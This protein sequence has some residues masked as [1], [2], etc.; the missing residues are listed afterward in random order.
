[1]VD[2]LNV[3][4][5]KVLKKELASVK[6]EL[7]IKGQECNRLLAELAFVHDEEMF[8]IDEKERRKIIYESMEIG[9]WSLY[10]KDHT[11]KRSIKHDQIFGYKEPLSEWTYEMFLDHVFP[12]DREYV[13]N[14]FGLALKNLTNWNFE[15]RIIRHDGEIRWIWACGKHQLDSKNVPLCITGIVMDITERKLIEEEARLGKHYNRSLIEACLDPLV[16]I[17]KQ[18]TI[19]DINTATEKAVGLPRESI[20]GTNFSLYFTDAAKAEIGYNL[21]F[22]YGKV[23][24]YELELKHSSG[25][26][27]PVLYNASVY[28]DNQNDVIGVFAVARDISSIKKLQKELSN[29]Q[30]LLKSSLESPKG[31]II[32][33]VD[34]HFNYLYFNETHKQTMK[35]I[36]NKEISVGIN[37]IEQIGVE[38]DKD[39][40]I[41]NFNLALNGVPHTTIQEYGGISKA[42]YETSYNPIFGEN[43]EIIGA[44]AFAM[45]ITDRKLAEL[46]LID[47]EEKFKMLYTSMNQGLAIFKILFDSFNKPNDYIFIDINDSFMK[48]FGVAK[49]RII[50]RSPKEV[51]PDIEQTWID[52]FK[53][54][55][56]TGKPSYNECFLSKTG[57]YY[58]IYAYSLKI[59]QFAILVADISE[60]FIKEEEIVYLNY[61]VQL[62]GLYNL[63]FYE[64]EIKRIDTERNLPLT[65]SMG[66]V[67]GLKLVN[68]SFGHAVGDELLKNVAAVLKKGCR[69]D[70][71]ISRIG[72]DEFVI[73][74]PKTDSTKAE[75]VIARINKLAQRKKV[76]SLNISISFGFE[77]KT[78]NRQKIQDIFKKSEDRMYRNKL[79]ESASI[80]SQFIDVILKTLFERSEREKVHSKSVSEISVKIANQMNLDKADIL[81]IKIAGLMHDIGKIGIDIGLLSGTVE[82]DENEW[83]EIRRHPEIGYR[84][85]SSANE[86]SEIADFALEHHERWDGSGYPKG[87]KG[88]EISLFAR[89]ICIADAYDAMTVGRNYKPV[90]NNEEAALEISKCAGSQ[91][92]P[93]I[94][95]IFVEKIINTL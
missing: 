35:N 91:F 24:D 66:D 71:V 95:R 73:I 6:K 85:L 54:V 49:E 67:N 22:E 26:T 83:K 76:G 74:L 62:T 20:I 43:N 72:G 15:C 86:F 21:A 27:I 77:T 25:S 42:Y 55:A 40:S 92:D 39:N 8:N 31:M 29:Y 44:S 17:G 11:A 3:D 94:A 68:D 18:G 87:L 80:K 2:C 36:Y 19:T 53:K 1:M 57:K 5:A 32:L 41:Y 56:L 51:I 70:D 34:K 82:L 14:Q 78:T 84:I 65:I 61:H 81:Q 12:D 37:I 69:A 58:S 75:K 64:E 60:R 7:A 47:S 45:D 30:L 90:L 48:L 93:D 52:I 88:Q 4:A 33:S 38:K 46:A 28:R 63:R 9:E 16:T 13:D 10:L 23:E 79:Y 50:G 89:I 59:S